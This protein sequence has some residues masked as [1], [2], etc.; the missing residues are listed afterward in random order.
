MNRRTL[1]A[2]AGLLAVRPSRRLRA[3]DVPR[4]TFGYPMALPGR[5]PGDGFL[6]RHGFVCENVWYNRG[7]LFPQ[8]AIWGPS[9]KCMVTCHR[10]AWSV[11]HTRTCTRQAVNASRFS[12]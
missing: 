2:A 7:R 5:A 1:L 3:Q 6:I 8:N 4:P 9:P 10:G 11:A 12:A